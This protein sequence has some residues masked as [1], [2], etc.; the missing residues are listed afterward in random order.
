MWQVAGFLGEDW[1]GQ[2]STRPYSTTLPFMLCTG[3]GDSLGVVF[4]F[5]LL[6]LFEW[7]AAAQTMVALRSEQEKRW[8]APEAPPEWQEHWQI[9]VK[10]AAAATFG[11]LCKSN[12]RTQTWSIAQNML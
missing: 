12:S 4:G 7:L 11:L 8:E 3:I 5:A 2:T 1:N 9:W 10:M 6:A